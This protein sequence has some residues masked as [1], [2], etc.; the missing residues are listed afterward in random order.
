LLKR[1]LR[2]LTE[3]FLHLMVGVVPVALLGGAM[4]R[5]EAE[6]AAIGAYRGI[7]EGVAL[8]ADKLGERVVAS[9]WPFVGTDYRRILIVG[10]ALAGW[11]DKT[12]PALWPVVRA[13]TPSGRL[14]LLEATRAWAR[15]QP[16]PMWEVLR[17]G[18]RA[19]SAF[20]TLSEHVV[21]AL[22]P[23]GDGPWYSRHAWWN[24]FPLGWGDT[25]AGPVP[26]DALWEAQL[27]HVATLFRA[28][29]RPGRLEAPSV[30]ARCRRRA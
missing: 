6:H 10:Q 8:R 13:C 7:L 27:P 11:D 12:S 2:R 5:G 14:D 28:L 19:G 30:P 29:A 9:H 16:E 21:L 25:E 3:D 17:H 23:N 1:A 22:D 4:L 24:L 18:K 15:R 26:G 20:W